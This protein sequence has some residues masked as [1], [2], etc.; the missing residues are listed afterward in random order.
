MELNGYRS[1]KR[2]HVTLRGMKNAGK[3]NGVFGSFGR[4]LYTC[5]LSNREMAKQYGRVYFVVNGRPI[6]PKKF[7]YL[8]SFEVFRQRYKNVD[9]LRD[10]MLACGYDGIEIPGREMVNYLPKNVLYFEK[11]CELKRYFENTCGY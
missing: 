5:S 10:N 2:K 1:W 7:Q 8:N 9:I 4:G 6:N 11:E 3:E